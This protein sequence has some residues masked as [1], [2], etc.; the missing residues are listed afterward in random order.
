MQRLASLTCL[1]ALWCLSTSAATAQTLATTHPLDPLS[2]AEIQQ[3]I[4][5]LAASGRLPP[6]SLYPQI[7]LHEPP[8]ADVLAFKPGAAFGRAA[9]VVVFNRTEGRT[10]EAI[11]DLRERSVR[12][13][14]ERPGVQRS[15]G[16]RAT[17]HRSVCEGQQLDHALPMAAS[18]RSPCCG[19][20]G[21]M[22]RSITRS[23]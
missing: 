2:A 23:T 4:R 3:T 13:W 21:Y 18:L 20:I 19:G 22:P 1:C 5:I 16:H 12:A 10:Y 9:S 15:V 11:V 17:S 6:D 14:T 7:T 8:K